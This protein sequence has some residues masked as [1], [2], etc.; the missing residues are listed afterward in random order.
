MNR[1]MHTSIRLN[2]DLGRATRFFSKPDQMVRWLCS[3]AEAVSDGSAFSLSGVIAS[4]DHWHWHIETIEREKCIT[5]RCTDLLQSDSIAEFPLEIKLM[6]CTSLT[7]Y[8]TEIHVLQYSFE[9]S[10]AGDTLRAQYL[11]FW[12]MKLEALRALVNG[13]WIIEDKDLT[14]DL[15][16]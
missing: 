10:E 4:E 12:R 7:E 13:K 15:F 9:D 11:E 5:V 1:F 8:C 16:K 3:D 14:L 2:T 6:K